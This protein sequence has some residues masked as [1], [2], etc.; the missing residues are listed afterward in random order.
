MWKKKN[1]IDENL[2]ERMKVGLG[3]RL[4]LSEMLVLEK[5]IKDECNI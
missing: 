1:D 5:N 3:K 2:L 4:H